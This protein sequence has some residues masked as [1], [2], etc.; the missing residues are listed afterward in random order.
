MRLALDVM[1]GDHGSRVVVE[2]LRQALELG[3]PIERAFLV[4][5]Q[6]EIRK[7]LELLNFSDD[8]LTIE[9]APDVLTMSDKPT[10][11]LR[12][13]KNSSLTKAIELVKNESADCVLSLGNTGG[14]VAVA[15]VKL[16]PMEGI[17][18]PAFATVIPA[19][20][21]H[22]VLLDA[23]A[24]PECKPSNFLQFAIMGNVYAREILGYSKPRVGILSN[25]TEES[26]GTELTR[27][28]ATLCAQANFNFIGYVE[29]HDLFANRVDVVVTD[30][31]TGNIVLKT[32]ESMGKGILN[33]LRSEMTANPLR[34]L[35]AL[36][37]KGAFRGFKH[38]MDADVH[39]GAPLLGLNGSVFKA[40]GSAKEK[41]IMNAIRVATESVNHKVGQ[42]IQTEILL[43]R[44]KSNQAI[45]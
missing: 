32:C 33:V 35:G 28:A 1:G 27:E 13:K 36:F 34:K 7:N 43:E 12:Q 23:G 3:L 18:R 2:G 15:T 24:T 9:H 20:N 42:L 11:A 5:E 26:K 21:H 14:M 22:F 16:R 39:G 44:N 38:Q 4:G 19:P 31:F 25:G 10:A 29:G 40:H 30:G 41:A 17:D 8:R 45:D 6:S 37:A